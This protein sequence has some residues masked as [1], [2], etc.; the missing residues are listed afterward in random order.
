MIHESRISDEEFNTGATVENN[1]VF[2]PMDIWVD[3]ALHLD[4]SDVYKLK[5]IVVSAINRLE[6]QIENLPSHWVHVKAGN[7]KKLRYWESLEKK[8]N[9]L[10]FSLDPI[11]F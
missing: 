5:E 11:P 8:L 10:H 1:F 3:L 2:S 6:W 4:T 9:D 7:K